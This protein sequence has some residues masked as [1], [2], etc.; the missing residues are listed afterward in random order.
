MAEALVLIA[1]A[2]GAIA[3]VALGVARPGEGTA[4]ELAR[5]RASLRR[6][7]PLSARPGGLY[8]AAAVVT[9]L[10]DGAFRFDA[11]SPDTPGAFAL[12]IGMEDHQEPPEPAW[13][14]LT[15]LR[16]NPWEASLTFSSPADDLFDL[17][18]GA[19]APTPK[20]APD[21]D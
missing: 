20:G 13:S 9:D 19:T 11:V 12:F 2:L 8:L 4:A 7:A 1:V 21:A 16:K 10:G 5:W 17:L 6:P 14:P 18:T 15:A 3:V